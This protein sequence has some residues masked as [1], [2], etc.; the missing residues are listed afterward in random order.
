MKRRRSCGRSNPLGQPD[1]EPAPQP[2]RPG[3]QGIGGRAFGPGGQR[4]IAVGALI[5][6]DLDGDGAAEVIAATTR[7][8][9][10]QAWAH[11]DVYRRG[12][13]GGWTRMPLDRR[14]GRLRFDAV[15]VGDVDGDGRRDVAALGPDGE[16]TIY[17]SER[18]GRFAREK[19]RLA[20]PGRCGGA[21]LVATDLD[22]DGRADLVAAYA[23]ERSTSADG[24]CPS[25]GAL[26]AWRSAPPRAAP[27][28]PARD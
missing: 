27:R 26:M 14:E 9:G 18:N 15:A 17:L 24:R 10:R 16:T 1:R 3:Q 25:E 23:Q 21:A 13:S 11:L 7:F 8:E 28:V 2:D 22:A 4:G 5:L 6:A 19:A 12:P 20:A